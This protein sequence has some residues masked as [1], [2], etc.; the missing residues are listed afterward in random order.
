MPPHIVPRQA[1]IDDAD[2][3][4][5]ARAHVARVRKRCPGALPIDIDVW[6]GAVLAHL[7]PLPADRPWLRR[8]WQAPR[9]EAS[10][11]GG[12]VGLHLPAA[13]ESSS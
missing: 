12:R 7:A 10:W 4:D 3:L 9:G 1:T 13:R 6:V 8:R 11:V 2:L 5:F